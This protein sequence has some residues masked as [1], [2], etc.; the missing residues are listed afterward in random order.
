MES[1]RG[2]SR[3][4]IDEL[5]YWDTQGDQWEGQSAVTRRITHDFHSSDIQRDHMEGK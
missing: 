1:E 3:S 5:H 4:I 2:V